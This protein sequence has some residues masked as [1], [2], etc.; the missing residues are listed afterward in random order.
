MFCQVDNAD[1]YRLSLAVQEWTISKSKDKHLKFMPEINVNFPPLIL[2]SKCVAGSMQEAADGIIG[3]LHFEVPNMAICP[4]LCSG[5]NTRQSFTLTSPLLHWRGYLQ[6]QVD[7]IFKYMLLL[8]RCGIA[9]LCFMGQPLSEL[10]AF[11]NPYPWELHRLLLAHS[12]AGS[13]C[14]H[15]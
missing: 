3:N 4:R 13:L 6:N 5:L 1:H 15:H 7:L 12:T 14:G 11:S 10:S 9:C 2:N 8:K